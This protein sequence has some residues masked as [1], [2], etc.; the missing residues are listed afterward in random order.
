M[1]ALSVAL[2]AMMTACDNGSATSDAGPSADGGVDG[3]EPITLVAGP[4]ASD[5]VV[6]SEGGVVTSPDGRLTLTIPPGALESDET[7]TIS[8]VGGPDDWVWVLEPDGLTFAVPVEARVQLPDAWHGIVTLLDASS[9]GSATPV[10]VSIVDGAVMGSIGH[11]SSLWLFSAGGVDM[12]FSGTGVEGP[13]TPP[14]LTHLSTG[15]TDLTSSVVSTGTGTFNL[16]AG[17]PGSRPVGSSLHGTLRSARVSS[18]S[19]Q[20][21]GLA[22]LSPA[23]QPLDVE[24]L[25]AGAS[26]S[27]TASV[28]CTAVGHATALP[29]FAVDGTASAILE[30][31][32]AVLSGEDA[33]RAIARLLS[34]ELDDIPFEEM[35]R[36]AGQYECDAVSPIIQELAGTSP[37][38]QD[39]IARGDK[40]VKD[41]ACTVHSS[42]SAC[43]VPRPPET[44]ERTLDPLL[45][46]GDAAARRIFDV[47]F[48]CGDGPVGLTVCADDVTPAP[49]GEWVFLMNTMGDDVPLA[50]STGI[51]QHAFVFDADGITSNNYV[52]APA[53]PG[54]FFA[55]TDL[56]YE[57]TYSP[58]TGWA[59][60]ARD[61]RLGLADVPSQARFI[62]AGKYIAFLVPRSE[63]DGASP[64]FRTSAFRH[65]G[66][67]GLMGGP[68][69]GDY[70]PA[71]DDPLLPVMTA[72]IPITD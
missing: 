13:W 46:L 15:V 32:V 28:V 62:I 4:S 20:V 47:A 66:D 50:D 31:D 7:I 49:G 24:F 25:A 41:G 9:D 40:A 8:D 72:S 38:T 21:R 39:A 71:L 23:G 33:T 36:T 52:P 18:V 59:I 10:A 44:I 58:G 55:G 67:F 19:W 48:P 14:Q 30:R 26:A 65:E 54:D 61:V 42:G 5:D 68:W 56:W 45:D 53:Y 22:L 63:L 29:D 69:S 3:G 6:A 51:Y 37:A 70:Y 2:L 11:F 43:E 34:G 64:G 35:I 17:A 57:L 12:E 60:R 27:S 1:S 16:S